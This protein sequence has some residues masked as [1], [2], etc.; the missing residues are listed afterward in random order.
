MLRR[1]ALPTPLFYAWLLCCL[2][3]WLLLVCCSSDRTACSCQYTRYLR[4]YYFVKFHF[5]DR[6][7]CHAERSEESETM[8]KALVCSQN[9][10]KEVALQAEGNF[11]SHSL[12][13]VGLVRILRCAQHD[14][15]SGSTKFGRLLRRAKCQ[16]QLPQPFAVGDGGAVG[17]QVQFG[18]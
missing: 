12:S 10:R 13:L 15:Q 4:T 16:S 1:P 9:E 11:F 18:L 17:A 2:S 7:P 14:R 5:V 3:S 6:N 8:W